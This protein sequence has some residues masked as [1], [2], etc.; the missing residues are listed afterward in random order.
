MGSKVILVSLWV[1]KV[2]FPIEKD[3]G[4]LT[5][6][7]EIRERASDTTMEVKLPLC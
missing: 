5:V 1:T 2:K 4:F 3:S 6:L 7:V